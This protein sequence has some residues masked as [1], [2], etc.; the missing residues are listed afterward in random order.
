MDTLAP[1]RHRSRSQHSAD[2]RSNASKSSR[3]QKSRRAHGPSAAVPSDAGSVASTIWSASGPKGRSTR[4]AKRTSFLADV[5]RGFERSGQQA[6]ILP[7]ILSFVYIVKLSVGLGSFSGEGKAPL[8]GDLEAQRNWLSVTL[9]RPIAEWYYYRLGHW[10]LDYPPL[11]AYHSLLMAFIMH[12]LSF[13]GSAV[14][15]LRDS[16][17]VANQ[18][19]IKV[20]MRHSVVIS[21]LVL[22]VPAVVAGWVGCVLNGRGHG[23]KRSQRTR[24]SYHILFALLA[25]ICRRQLLSTRSCFNQ[26]TS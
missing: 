26:P 14:A 18:E 7:A 23:V 17:N 5:L 20:W 12:H 9:H 2:H 8:Y 3:V 25:E 11:T 16:G 6:F 22:W 21:E 10:G 1:L 15:A 19:T 24:V 13:S 4:A